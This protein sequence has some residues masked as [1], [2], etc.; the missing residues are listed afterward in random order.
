VPVPELRGVGSLAQ[1][2]AATSRL[3][4][5]PP[6]FFDAVEE[7]PLEVAAAQ[8]S[9]TDRAALGRSTARPSAARR[10]RTVRSLN[11]S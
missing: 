10:N 5:Y 6:F 7:V 8:T 1:E 4:K 9:L 11:Q 3:T 2:S